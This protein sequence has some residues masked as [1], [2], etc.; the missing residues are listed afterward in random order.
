V[1]RLGAEL[2]GRHLVAV[3]AAGVLLLV[4]LVGSIAVVSRAGDHSGELAPRRAAR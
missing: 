1:A 4:A 2:F 3:E